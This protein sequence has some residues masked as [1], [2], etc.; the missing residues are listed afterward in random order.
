MQLAAIAR[1]TGSCVWLTRFVAGRVPSTTPTAPLGGLVS[2]CSRSQVACNAAATGSKVI[3]LAT[4][5]SVAPRSLQAA[6]ARLAGL[7]N[8]NPQRPANLQPMPKKSTPS[9]LP[10]RSLERR[11]SSI[12]GCLDA[13]RRGSV[14][15]KMAPVVIELAARR[16]AWCRTYACGNCRQGAAHGDPYLRR[17]WCR[18]QLFCQAVHR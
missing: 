6:G 5:V 11:I 14:I 1:N 17:H 7:A 9:L 10:W 16:T 13:T 12:L 2:G 18:Q 8:G 15:H 4:R 3:V